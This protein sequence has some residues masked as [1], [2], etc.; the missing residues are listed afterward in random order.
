MLRIALLVSAALSLGAAS[1]ACAGS[2]DA[3]DVR[4]FAAL[5]Q[6]SLVLTTGLTGL[7]GAGG[8]RDAYTCLD[9][10]RSASSDL[11]TRL[12]NLSDLVSANY[13]VDSSANASALSVDIR[14]VRSAMRSVRARISQA[15]STCDRSFLFQLQSQKLI[16][17]LNDTSQS[18]GKLKGKMTVA[19]SGAK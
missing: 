8:G 16:D 9:T 17:L 11:Y 10:L 5:N 19:D 13:S 6:R 15:K 3:D 18:L 4:A 7:E 1:A 14:A 2:V 12:N